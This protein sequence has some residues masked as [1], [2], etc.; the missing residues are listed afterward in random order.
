MANTHAYDQIVMAKVLGR[1]IGHAYASLNKM[2][3]AV[4]SIGWKKPAGIFT[5]GLRKKYRMNSTEVKAKI[6]EH[7]EAI[8][9]LY[10]KIGS[11][12]A[13]SNDVQVFQNDEVR[14]VMQQIKVL[15]K[16]IVA[17]KRYL[18]ELENTTGRGTVSRRSSAY[19]LDDRRFRSLVNTC[20]ARAKF[21]LKSDAIIFEK[22]LADVVSY[23]NDI[24]RLAVSELGRLGNYQAVPVLLELLNS[25]DLLLQGEI[26]NALDLLEYSG[27][28]DVCRKFIGSQES[29][30]RSACVRGLYKQ[31]KEKAAPYL[32]E[33]LRDENMEVRAS[34]A[35]FLGWLEAKEAVPALLQTVM[36]PELR[37]SKNAIVS[38]SAIRDGG[39][40]LPLMRMLDHDEKEI[41]EK[42]V[43]AL[44][45]LTGEQI[46][47]KVD[48]AQ[49]ERKKEIA[50]LKDWWIGR[51]VETV[52]GTSKPEPSKAKVKEKG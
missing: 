30:I 5:G 23:E 24:Q 47:F 17:L 1:S 32:M 15:E 2:A 18:G 25:E 45:R 49:A 13:Q 31:G 29:T 20:R 11:V 50:G 40:I 38:L 14:G 12:G 28:F 3:L 44:E 42:I 27:L 21:V 8:R 10:Q 48:V 16:N 19:M 4:A 9:G 39:A 43:V 41:R 22:A 51:N 46:K 26:I 6:I 33:A 35:M 37:V 52:T 36:D 34:A 7:E